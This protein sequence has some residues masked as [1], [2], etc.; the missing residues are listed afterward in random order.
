MRVKEI[1]QKKGRAG[2]RPNPGTTGRGGT[3]LPPEELEGIAK[4]YTGKIRI[5]RRLV[6]AGDVERRSEK[7]LCVLDACLQIVVDLVPDFGVEFGAEELG[8]VIVVTGFL[9]L[10]VRGNRG[11][12]VEEGLADSPIVADERCHQ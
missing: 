5:V 11:I 7:D 1:D 6:G 4:E 12:D 9:L 2:A 10:R 3:P 8:L